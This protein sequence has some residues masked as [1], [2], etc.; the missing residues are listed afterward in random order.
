MPGL[1][2]NNEYISQSLLPEEFYSKL[3][4]SFLDFTGSS[5]LEYRFSHDPYMPT[6]TITTK[7]S[8]DRKLKIFRPFFST[9]NEFLLPIEGDTYIKSVWQLISTRGKTIHLSTKL[10]FYIAVELSDEE[11]RSIKRISVQIEN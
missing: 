8:E 10:R 2:A 3:K 6:K 9:P 4:I 5:V 11:M 1:R 7:R